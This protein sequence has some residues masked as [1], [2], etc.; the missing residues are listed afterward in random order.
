[1]T[2]SLPSLHLIIRF[3][4]CGRRVNK[5]EKSEKESKEK[6]EASRIKKCKERSGE[7]NGEKNRENVKERELPIGQNK[8]IYR[9][10]NNTQS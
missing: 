8:T 6:S 3:S 1:M 9:T 4:N 7:K 10:P 2:I 5:S